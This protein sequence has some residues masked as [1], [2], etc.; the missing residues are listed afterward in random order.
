MSGELHVIQ[1]GFMS[2]FIGLYFMGRLKGNN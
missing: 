2:Y 1:R